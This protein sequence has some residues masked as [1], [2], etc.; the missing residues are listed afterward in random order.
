MP[1]AQ[2]DYLANLEMALI[3]YVERY[4][5]S[6]RARSAFANRPPLEPAQAG[7]MPARMAKIDRDAP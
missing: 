2:D 3:D 6:D 4:G 1:Q 7:Q 5:L